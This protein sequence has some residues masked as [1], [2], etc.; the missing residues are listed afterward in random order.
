MTDHTTEWTRDGEDWTVTVNGTEYR[1][2][3][4]AGIGEPAGTHW[5]RGGTLSRDVRSLGHALTAIRRHAGLS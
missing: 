2:T 1:A 3:P 4:S 5:V